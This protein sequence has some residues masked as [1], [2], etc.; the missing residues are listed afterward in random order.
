MSYSKFMIDPKRFIDN[1]ILPKAAKSSLYL[2]RKAIV[3]AYICLFL[4]IL[5]LFFAVATLTFMPENKDVPTTLGLILGVVLL[6][7][8]KKTGS[9]TVS[10]NF[11]AAS[12]TIVVA[13]SVS[14]TGGLFSD[15]LLWL[16]ITP[17]IALLFANKK[18]GFFWLFCLLMFTGYVFLY[19]DS[20]SNAAYFDNR[21]YYFFS[22]SF[23]FIAI[24]GTVII[25]ETGQ[26]LIIKMLNKQKALLEQQKSLLEQQKSL[27][28]QQKE[29]I[30]Q[31]NDALEEIQLTLRRSNAELENFA[32]VASHDLKEPLRMIRMYSGFTQKRLL[33][34][35]DKSTHE[36]MGYINDGA[37]RMEAL[38]NDLLQYSRL[39]KKK[40]DIKD[41]DLNNT[42]FIVINN[43]LATMK[44]TDASIM[45]NK[46]PIIEATHTEMVQLFQN[47]IANSIKF[48][49]QGV[50]PEIKILAQDNGEQFL[51]SFTDNGIGI[52]EEYREKVFGIFEK[53]HSHT[54]Y[55]GTGIGLATCKKIVGSVGGNIWLESTEG[56]GTTFFFT[57]PKPSL[58]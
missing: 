50:L 35:P 10:G 5:S 41:I 21:Q 52:K 40:E 45:A 36:Y 31:K 9:L 38:L 43:M 47:L 17:L 26:T 11:L 13:P 58:N 46:L 23:L 53:L 27:L 19:S 20:S 18:S 56:V 37:E 28:E 42:L 22:Y 16:I 2:Y 55:E 3:L 14:M 54:E 49:R 57:L 15:N 51:I 34:H 30:S 44:D 24:F 29:E 7:V 33:G 48:R 4:T 6:F 12:Y 8:F 1:L 25:F 32:F 39:G